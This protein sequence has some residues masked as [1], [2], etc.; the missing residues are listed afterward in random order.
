MCQFHLDQE[1]FV[2]GTLNLAVF[3]CGSSD[4]L[5]IPAKIVVF[6]FVAVDAFDVDDD[7]DDDEDDDKDDIFDF[8]IVAVGLNLP[9]VGVALP[10]D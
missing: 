4:F 1:Q 9:L 8:V 5:Q 3:V 2:S 6:G 7:D 10:K